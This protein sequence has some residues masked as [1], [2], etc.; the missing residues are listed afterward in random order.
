MRS[1]CLL[2]SVVS[3][4][5]SF[6]GGGSSQYPRR[7][8]ARPPHFRH[9][10]LPP[11]CAEP[12]AGSWDCV[13]GSGGEGDSGPLW[14]TFRLPRATST[15]PVLPSSASP[16]S[17]HPSQDKTPSRPEGRGASPPTLSSFPPSSVPSPFLSLSSTLLGFQP[18]PHTQSRCEIGGGEFGQGWDLTNFLGTL[19][20]R[21]NGSDPARS[22]HPVRQPRKWEIIQTDV[23]TH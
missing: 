3:P 17:E 10:Y 6:W 8:R 19:I 22:G 14:L 23:K 7:C 18:A 13:R 20:P 16:L 9:R 15:S 11:V 12:P 4:F 21:K 2:G 5:P 1:H